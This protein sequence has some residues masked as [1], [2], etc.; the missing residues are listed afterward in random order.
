MKIV[1]FYLML[2]A[3]C[4]CLGAVA[5]AW[6]LTAPQGQAMFGCGV[7]AGILGGILFEAKIR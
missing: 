6:Y 7:I 3:I 1:G 2:L 4:L 5:F